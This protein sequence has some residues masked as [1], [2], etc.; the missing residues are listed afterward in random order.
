[1]PIT[2]LLAT[3]GKRYRHLRLFFGALTCLLPAWAKC[4][5]VSRRKRKTVFE[6]LAASLQ[7]SQHMWLRH[8]D[9]ECKASLCFKAACLLSPP[10]PSPEGHSVIS[11]L[12]SSWS[13]K[14]PEP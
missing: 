7:P 8:D 13:C 4:D 2:H 10:P 12:C 14:A 5:P 6:V 9:E 1:M 3:R 11:N